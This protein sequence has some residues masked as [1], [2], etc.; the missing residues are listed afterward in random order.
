MLNH[1]IDLLTRRGVR[2]LIVVA[3]GTDEFDDVRTFYC[4]SNFVEEARIR[5]FYAAGVDKV[6]CENQWQPAEI[7]LTTSA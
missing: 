5:E 1:V 3:S 7:C 4:K 6:V 2:I